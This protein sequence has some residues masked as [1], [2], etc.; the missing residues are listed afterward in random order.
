MKV[1]ANARIET[2]SG[3]AIPCGGVLVDGTKIAAV[4]DHL[5]APEG[6]EVIEARGLTLTPGLIDAHTHLATWTEAALYGLYDYNE[7]TNPITPDLRIMDAVY[8]LDPNI[9]E[10]RTGGVTCVQTLPGSANLIGGQG[11]ILKL[12]DTHVVDEMI[13]KAPSCMKAALGEN[14]VRVYKTN[15]HKAPTTR[16]ANAA[17]MR[18]ALQN[19]R[20]YMEKKKYYDA[21][22]EHTESFETKLDMEA[23]AMVLRGEIPLSV[24]C[25]RSDDICTATRIAEE[26]GVRFTIEHCTEGHL[27]APW[28]AEHSVKAAVGPTFTAAEKLELKNK[29]WDTLPVLRDAGVHVC[30]ITDHPVIPLYGLILCASLAHKAGLSEAEALRAVTL[31][32]AE[33]LGIDDRTGSIDAGKDADLV[34]WSGNPLDSRS[35]VMMT[36][37]DGKVEHS[38]PGL[39]S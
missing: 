31:S 28:L 8:P 4:G 9:A 10:A 26:F 34:L 14:P 5:G 13:V 17:V 29:T 37:I 39:C 12:K 19:A 24:H 23:L 15:G 18:T 35:R 2:V 38:V 16:M 32:G 25:H 1:I 36:M 27:I 21:K 22:A 11:A 6:T 33:H 7:M 3:A 20:N 30:I